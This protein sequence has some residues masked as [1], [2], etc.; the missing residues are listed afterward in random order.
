V[1]VSLLRKVQKHILAEPKRFDMGN[2]GYLLP[3]GDG[4]PKCG[5]VGCIA[6]WAVLLDGN[7]K[8][9]G[10]WEVTKL[11]GEEEGKDSL[12]LTELQKDRL[13]FLSG[14]PKKFHDK[15]FGHSREEQAK[16][17]AARI[18]HFIRTKGK[19]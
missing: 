16:I 5:T 15:Y 17:A 12:E 7:K 8:A 19:E 18:E 2:F 1:N 4:G 14:W 9:I 3:E 6:G 13:F 11:V 10:T